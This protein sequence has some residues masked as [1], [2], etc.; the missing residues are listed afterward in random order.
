[1]KKQKKDNDK[2]EQPTTP[3]KDRK[4]NDEIVDEPSKVQNEPSKVQNK[5]KPIKKP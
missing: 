1:M 3:E 5:P 2:E 4:D